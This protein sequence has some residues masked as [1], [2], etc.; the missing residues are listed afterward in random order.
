MQKAVSARLKDV[1]GGLVDGAHDGAASVDGVAYGAHHNGSC[2]GIQP[3][4][5]TA[6]CLAPR[7]GLVLSC[8]W[9]ASTQQGW[10]L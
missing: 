4:P 8:N 6:P 2:S 7:H 3:C 1:N 9:C 5:H 10:D